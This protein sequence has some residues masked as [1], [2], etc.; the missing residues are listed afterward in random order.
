MLNISYAY[1][2]S[3]V[4]QAHFIKVRSKFEV[5][6]FI[7]MY[8][9]CHK[10]RMFTYLMKSCLFPPYYDVEMVA[11]SVSQNTSWIFGSKSEKKSA[12]LIPYE[13]HFKFNN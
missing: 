10:K 4:E 13:A 7:I 9:D 5:I 2:C 1:R 8:S 3:D 12:K 6:G 11:T